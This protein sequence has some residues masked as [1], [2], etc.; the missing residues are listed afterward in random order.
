[1]P[2]DPT[3]P[4]FK[5][6]FNPRHGEPVPV[7]P[8]VVRIVA[9][10]A[11]PFT[12]TGTNSYLLGGKRLLV[13][14]P[15][16]DRVEHRDSLVRAIAG[17]R[18]EAIV[19][20]HTHH[21]HSA[22]ARKLAARLGAPIWFSGWHDGGRGSFRPDR[23]LA[24]GDRLAIDELVLEAIATPGHC[25]NHLAFGL[26]GT[27][28]LLSGDHVMG[29]SSTVLSTQ[30]GALDAYL[31][32]I[33]RLIA[34]PYKIYLPGHGDAVADGPALARALKAH[35]LQRNGQILAAIAAG[36]HMPGAITRVV[37]PGLDRLLR[38]GARRTVAAHLDHLVAH[39]R[40]KTR[41]RW[42]RAEYR[43]AD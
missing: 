11:G 36:A 9:P 24:D 27:P 32:S 37:Y 43:I 17:R 39:G 18:V 25:D 22:G 28:C 23:V 8:G 40:V 15:G 35:R 13:V 3:A 21:D 38:Q 34:S 41:R 2:P 20:T 16:P 7:A 33:D 12:F 1:M 5:R 4:V 10:N 30:K 26:V 31:A 42:W 29:W 6:D 14:D 19:L